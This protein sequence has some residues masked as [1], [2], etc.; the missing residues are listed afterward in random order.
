MCTLSGSPAAFGKYFQISSAVN[1]RIGAASR[2]SALVI[3]HTAV[4]A[5]RRD[6][7]FGALVYSRSFSTS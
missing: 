1:T 3:F 2:T 6:L 4:C 5:E 7:L